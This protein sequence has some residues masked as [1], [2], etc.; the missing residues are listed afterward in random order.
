MYDVLEQCLVEIEQGAD[1]D[2]VLF[3]YPEYA[4]ELRPIL[5]ASV[6]AKE[7]SAPEP[8]ADVV[9]RNRARVLQHAAEM[10]E[11]MVKPAPRFWFASLRRLAVTVTVILM[12]L[13]SSTGLVR[14]ASNTIPGDNLY[15]VKRTWEDIILLFTFNPQEREQLEF[16]HENERLE[17]LTE[18]FTEGRSVPV[19]FAGYVSR[20]SATEWRVSG[21]TVVFSAQTEMPNQPVTVGD[22]VRIIG[23]TQSEK[24][25]LAERIELLPSGS[26]LPEVEDIESDHQEENQGEQEQQENDN[27]NSGSDSGS[28]NE[29]PSVEV[30]ETP[31]PELEPVKESSEGILE[32][33]D[34]KNKIWTINGQ[35]MDV[36]AAEIKGT[37]AIGATVKVEGYFD[38]NGAFIATKIEFVRSD[39][40][41][42]SG[43][44]DNNSNDDNNNDNDNGNDQDNDNGDDKGNDNGN[45]NGNSG[46][47]DD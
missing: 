16:E 12:M 38:S 8:S 29:A 18:L 44:N 45:D 28:E 3:R 1:V 47:S 33:M 13:V 30:T 26:K 10:R 23:H 32:V 20:R 21:I 14:A 46:G 34:E 22:A 42:D 24:T 37:P 35:P 31:K 7:M 5:E 41:P 17:E 19:D 2:T 40:S 4:D 6:K 27:S 15:P 36:S 25:V 11:G 39:S 43:Q 9:R